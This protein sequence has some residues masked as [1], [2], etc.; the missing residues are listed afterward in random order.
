M[1]E[2]FFKSEIV[3]SERAVHGGE[4]LQYFRS[5][6]IDFSS[7]VNP[8]GTPKK[9]LAAVKRE[10]WKCAHYPGDGR[11]LRKAASLHF[12]VAPENVLLGSGSTELIKVFCEGFLRGEDKVLI[13]APTYSDYEAF[14]KLQGTKAEHI[15][16]KKHNNFAAEKGV[17][18]NRIDQKTKALFLCNPNNPTGQTITDN[19]LE[20]IIS[21][22][23]NCN[24]IVFLDEA[25]IDFSEQRTL[26]ERVERFENLF[27]LR[28]LTK[29]FALPGLRI[30]CGVANE[31]TVR[32]LERLLPTWNINSLAQAAARAALRDES[33]IKKSKAFVKREKEFLYKS[34]KEIPNLKVYPSETN[35]F[36]IE[37]LTLTAR[38]LKKKL[39]QKRILIR[40]CSSF[41]GLGEKFIRVC[42]RKRKENL[43]LIG[44]LRR[45]VK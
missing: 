30:G 43:K 13:P 18:I 40:D 17:I 28:S 34:L 14:A 36:L 39:L 42:V 31:K 35:F 27:V 2:Q 9:A 7:N 10:L 37:L 19:D 3:S 32:Y 33:Y 11:E 12:G 24:A 29:F 26:C 44:E 20:E 22:A 16:L 1:I 21:E 45:L 6:F 15:F 25:Y 4:A 23:R 5:G 38:E 8:L 41:A